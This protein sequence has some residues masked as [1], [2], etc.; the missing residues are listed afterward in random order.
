MNEALCVVHVLTTA[1]CWSVQ[2]EAGSA[3]WAFRTFQEICRTPKLKWV[4]RDK[5]HLSNVQYCSLPT[6]PCSESHKV[7]SKGSSVWDS[8]I[9]KWSVGPEGTSRSRFYFILASRRARRWVVPR[10]RLK[11]R[12]S[13]WWRMEEQRPVTRNKTCQ[14]GSVRLRCGTH[15]LCFTRLAL[16]DPPHRMLPFTLRSSLTPPIQQPKR[17]DGKTSQQREKTQSYLNSGLG[18]RIFYMYSLWRV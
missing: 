1:Q 8:D 13:N 7:K 2:T 12:A 15:S 18:K 6:S 5:S 11:G 16:I 10:S 9:R 4:M 17:H 14:F 3:D